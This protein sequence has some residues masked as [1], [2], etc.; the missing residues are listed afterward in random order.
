M[1]ELV[2]AITAAIAVILFI[3][4]FYLRQQLLKT[5]RK[6]LDEARSQGLQIISEATKASQAMMS[7]AEIDA[8]KVVANGKLEFLKN[9]TEYEKKFFEI[10]RNLNYAVNTDIDESRKR[11]AGSEASVNNHIQSLNQTLASNQ[12]TSQTY[13]QQATQ[14]IMNYFAES[15]N[16]LLQDVQNK[17]FTQIDHDLQSSRQEIKQYQVQR[18]KLVE[19]NI[20]SIVERTVEIVI[21]K[22]LSLEDKV[23]TVYE[24]FERAKVE[25]TFE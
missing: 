11:I 14:E 19:D 1:P 4:E 8:V 12:Q 17:S 23:D 9:Q 13:V 3:R 15:V 7:E 16:H 24:S 10:L 25:K 22:E 5:H 20:M 2:L 18:M 6:V 21:T